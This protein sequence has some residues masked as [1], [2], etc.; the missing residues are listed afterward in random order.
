MKKYM[1]AFVSLLLLVLVA[2]GLTHHAAAF[3]PFRPN[4][5]T[6]SCSQTDPKGNQS[7]VCAANGSNPLTG[8]NGLITKG[9]NIFAV[10]T[11]FAAIVMIIIGGFEYVRSGGE[12]AKIDKAKNTILFSV[13]GLVVVVL[14]RAIVALVIS[15]L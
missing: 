7:T 9:A 10:I 12:S 5:D 4:G 14:A 13:I 2:T 11:G 6:A 1:L 3:D 8:D 15:R